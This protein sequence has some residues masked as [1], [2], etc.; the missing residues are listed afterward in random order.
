MTHRSSVNT[1]RPT[2]RIAYSGRTKRTSA[3]KLAIPQ[4]RVLILAL[5]LVA[6]AFTAAIAQ[7]ATYTFNI[8]SSGGADG[9][10]VGFS[11]TGTGPIEP[12][13]VGEVG[14]LSTTAYRS[15]FD[16]DIRRLPETEKVVSA[17]LG[18]R[19]SQIRV[20]GLLDPVASIRH[21]DASRPPRPSP[22]PRPT[23][24][25]PTRFSWDEIATAPQIGSIVVP[26]N[27]G[28]LNFYDISEAIAHDHRSGFETSPVGLLEEPRRQQSLGY[29]SFSLANLVIET[30]TP[31]PVRYT[32]DALGGTRYRY[33]YTLQNE[34]SLPLQLLD[35][36]F[37]PAL[38]REDTLSVITP[39]DLAQDWEPFL[40]GSG[41]EVPAVISLAA[42]GQGLAGGQAA[43]GFQV[44]FDWLGSDPPGRQ[45]FT[46][47]DAQS[48]DVLY[49]GHTRLVPVPA[50]GWLLLSALA[51]PG[52]FTAARAQ[53]ARAGQV[54]RRV[55]RWPV[56]GSR[57]FSQR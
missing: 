16:F 33:T 19:P 54:T 53:R 17:T 8:T 56:P 20:Q 41:I 43:R 50:A 28:A 36:E 55:R 2:E 52:L 45:P 40:L 4:R 34:I 12:A 3:P 23:I 25:D 26:L 49:G 47:Y 9:L 57:T 11:R 30:A 37:D 27:F 46:V 39:D 29:V 22:F 31:A 38:Y 5:A 6:S 18:L 1:P 42:T 21:L 51:A 15:I 14:W 32:V 35:L 7:A 13:F 24:A 44:E 10:G 48:F